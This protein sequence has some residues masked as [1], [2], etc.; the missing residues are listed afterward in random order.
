[1]SMS[2]DLIK[3]ELESAVMISGLRGLL[4]Q[5]QHADCACRRPQA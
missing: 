1:M 3:P 5:R 4:A 2:A